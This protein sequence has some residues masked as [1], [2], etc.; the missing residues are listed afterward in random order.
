MDYQFTHNVDQVTVNFS[1]E[2]E[3]I[4]NWFNIE[5]RLNSDLIPTALNYLQQAKQS[6]NEKEFSLIGNEFSVFIHSDEVM[7]KANNLAIE[8]HDE[9][10]ADFH[11]Y[12]EE[13]IAFC[14]LEDFEYFLKSY[15]SFIA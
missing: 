6:R 7:I 10:E 2:H 4:A 3:A 9:L 5:V 1:M 12:D 13:S 8:E 15:L 11:Y 14:G